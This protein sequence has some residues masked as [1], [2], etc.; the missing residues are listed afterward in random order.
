[1]IKGNRMKKSS[2]MSEVFMSQQ[3]ITK[4][5]KIK[6]NVKDYTLITISTLLVVLGVYLFKFPNNFSFG[7]V[8]GLAVVVSKITAISPSTITN[9]VNAILIV[10]GFIFLG[11]EFGVKTV[12]VTILTTVGL[13]VMEKLFPMTGP[14]TNQPFLELIFAVILPAVG[15]AILFNIGASSGGTDILAMILKKHTSFN[16]GTALFVTDVIVVLSAFFIFDVQ[17][18]LYSS[19][20]LMMKSVFI[21][22]VIENI[23]LCKYFNVMCDNPEPICEYITKELNRSATICRAEGAYSHD[24]K[25]IIFTALKR[26]QAVQLRNYLKKVEPN[27]FILISNTSEIIGNGFGH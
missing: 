7:G 20:G 15:S 27:A 16:I 5:E 11:K 12:Y 9:I 21:D 13:S 1:M 14:L 23:N 4:N 17:T 25:A 2:H 10:V 24:N 22:S 19:L 18:G 8:T 6:K 3:M 26:S